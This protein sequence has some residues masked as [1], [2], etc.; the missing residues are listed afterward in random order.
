MCIW[1]TGQTGI[2][3]YITNMKLQRM[4]TS[5]MYIGRNRFHLIFLKKNQIYIVNKA[6]H[7]I[8]HISK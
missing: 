8:H 2:Q 5:L 4:K 6:Q 1:T 3:L 7:F